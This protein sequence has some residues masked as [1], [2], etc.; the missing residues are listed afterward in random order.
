ML[1][2]GDVLYSRYW[3]T[4]LSLMV[5]FSS[6]PP[7]G[8]VLLLAIC[9]GLWETGRK[10]GK[11]KKQKGKS[12]KVTFFFNLLFGSFSLQLQDMS[13]SCLSCPSIS[14]AMLTSKVDDG[15]ERHD[16]APDGRGF[17]AQGSLIIES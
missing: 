17:V 2:C 9:V 14:P 8:D 6:T 11:K 3:E 1:H 13:P 16:K 4:F 12:R 7:S 10:G 5:S 15:M